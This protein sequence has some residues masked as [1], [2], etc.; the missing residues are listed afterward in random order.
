V[1]CANGDSDNVSVIDGSSDSVV[2]TVTAGDVPWVLS[3]NRTSNKI[4]CA[5]LGSD[6]VTVIDGSSNSVLHTIA[7]GDR[8]VALCHNPAQNRVY[9]SNS[10]SASISVLRDSAGGVEEMANGEG[11]MANSGPSVLRRLPSGA[12]AFDASGRRVTNPK[13]GIY[14]VRAE[15]SAVTVRKVIIQR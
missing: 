1:Y 9:V 6:D 5:N 7:V 4:Y 8:P 2:A 12:V 3:Y 15:P 14:F 11:R 10:R 13:S